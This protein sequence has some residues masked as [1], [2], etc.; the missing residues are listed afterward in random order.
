LQFLAFALLP[1]ASSCLPFFA[2]KCMP[3]ASPLSLHRLCPRILGHAYALFLFAYSL[4]TRTLSSLTHVPCLRSLR[5]FS[6]N[7]Y[8]F[9]AYS[10]ATRTLSSL[11]HVP[12]VCSLRLPTCHAYS[13][14]AHSFDLS[15]TGAYVLTYAFI[16]R[17]SS[18]FRCFLAVLFF[19][20]L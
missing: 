18:F 10:R 13:L 7:A 1:S 14:F 11:T 9:F 19:C 3:S 16:S 8:A 4:A 20:T 15:C 6:C 2:F 12:R 5:L 17:H